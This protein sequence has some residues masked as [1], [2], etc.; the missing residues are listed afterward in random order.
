MK[1]SFVH[2]RV[3]KL[4]TLG[5]AFGLFTLLVSLSTSEAGITS[6][7]IREKSTITEEMIRLGKISDIKGDDLSLNQKLE[8]LVIGRSPLPSKSRH[9]DK[10]YIEV[11]LKQNKIDLSMVDIRYPERIEVCRDYLRI[12]KSRTEEIIGNYIHKKMPWN[13]ESV[14][15]K[16][17]NASSDLILP[18]GNLTYEVVPPKY[19][20]FMGRTSIPVVF[21]VNDTFQKKIWVTVEI[22]VFGDVLVSSIPLEKYRIVSREDVH[23]KRMNLADLPRGMITRLEDVIG[24][25][26]KAP[27]AANFV[28]TA[29][30]LDVPPVVKRG[31]LVTIVAETDILKVTTPGEAREDG[32]NGE[33]IR[34]LNIT[35]RKEVYG[36]VVNFS[37]VKVEF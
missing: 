21:T 3:V 24:K 36:R 8:T 26:T 7:T 12:P 10:E 4:L 18:K 22:E 13:K 20:D 5:V 23:V 37:T 34:V 14:R 32:L 28:I 6:V 15:I 16:M 25:R 33:I 9:I 27:I 2:L 11:R 19:W 35:S 1:W 30:L 29:N 17:I 31:D